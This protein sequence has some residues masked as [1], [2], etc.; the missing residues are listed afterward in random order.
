MVIEHDNIIYMSD[1]PDVGGTSTY[2]L[3]LAKRYKDRDIG[4]VYKTSQ[5]GMISK[6]RKYCRVYQLH[7]E[8][9]IRCK[10]MIINHDATV[11]DQVDEGKIYMTLHADYSNEIYKGGHPDFR[12]RIDGYISITKGIQKWLKETCNKDS[13]VIYNPLTIEDNKPLILMSATRM[14]KAKG[15]DRCI[16][17]GNALNRAGV[18]YIWFIFTPNRDEIDNPNI[19]YMKERTDLE[20]FMRNSRLRRTAL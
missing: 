9:R 2:V 11:C 1:I 5:Y 7:P 14:S 4:I 3:Q 6:L 13:E 16:A 15:K 10:V 20:R 17:L 19:I 18:N 12:D 8:D